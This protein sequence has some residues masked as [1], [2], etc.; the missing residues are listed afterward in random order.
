MAGATQDDRRRGRGFHALPLPIN[1]YPGGGIKTRTMDRETFQFALTSLITLFIVVDPIG[2]VPIFT[3]M[4][5]PMPRGL[6]RGVVRRA[7]FV[8]F[9]VA[10]GFLLIGDNLLG[11]LGVSLYAFSI[12]GG[13]LLFITALP[14]LFGGRGGLQSPEQAE[15]V[16]EGED[17]AI[18]P[19]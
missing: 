7:I 12:S 19:L 10:L 3:T 15:H 11:Y 13:I 17:I 8:A 16:T 4:T 2:L 18:F 6:R 14:M 9:F 5:K 1:L